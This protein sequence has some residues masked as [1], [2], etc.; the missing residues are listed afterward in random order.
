M[1]LDLNKIFQKYSSECDWLGLRTVQKRSQWRSM[2]DQRP[3]KNNT[4][5]EQGLMMEVV[6]DGQLSYAATSHTSPDGIEACFRHARDSSIRN[7]KMGL[8]LFDP[9]T[10]GSMS[11]EYSS[12]KKTPLSQYELTDLIQIQ[13]D[14]SHILASVPNALSYW[15]H[16]WFLETKMNYINSN[17]AQIT[18]DFERIS[19][20]LGITA[21]KGDVIQTRSDGGL[22]A[23]S[24]QSG[25]E[26]IKKE[27]SLEGAE[28]L[29]V[30]VNELLDAPECPSQ[31]CD[32]LVMPNQ[33]MLQIHESIGHPLELDRILGDERNYA[34]SSFIR[35]NDFGKLQYGSDLMNVTFDPH[36]GGEFASYGFDDTG[37]MADKKYLI[38]KGLLKNGLGSGE[39]QERHSWGGVSN[40]RSASWNRAPIDRMANI[41]LEPGHS[42]MQEMISSI[43]N[44][45]L[46]DTNRSWSIDDYRNKF[47]FGCEYGKLIQD[48]E[49][50]HVVKNPNYRGITVPFWNSLKMLG[51]RSTHQ[52]YGTPFCGKGEPNQII[53]VGHA[54][55]CALFKDIEVFGGES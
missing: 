38:E 13:K 28:R 5:I 53:D 31:N 40:A 55:P 32:L 46:V 47:Q 52:I 11:G 15:V 48:G 34:G 22:F 39:S 41:N 4:E 16:F 29:G 8:N 20:T 33:M 14:T 36:A 24:Y 19:Q 37:L 1:N 10:R 3:D 17:G 30:E 6:I 44:G 35:P 43:E 49:V 12:E 50:K 45:I 25:A 23:H 26:G 9:K 42:G 21:Q 7:K 18:Q 54:S 2:L 27:Q 51:D